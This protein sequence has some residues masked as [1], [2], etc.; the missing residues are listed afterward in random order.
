MNDFENLPI[1]EIKAK[2]LLMREEHEAIKNEIIILA[3][4]LDS[5]A[6]DYDKCDEIIQDR[7][8]S[9]K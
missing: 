8:K 2:Q 6:A 1:T 3:N 7:I 4:K 9:V 5:I